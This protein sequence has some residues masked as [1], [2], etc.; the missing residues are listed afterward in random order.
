[1]PRRDDSALPAKGRIL[2]IDPGERRIGVAAADLDTRV[3]V[4][5]TTL[6]ADPDPVETVVACVRE[7]EAG[8]VVVGLALSM[9]G[10]LGA[11][12]QRAQAL[13]DALAERLDI[14]VY[15]WDE[16]LTSAEARRRLAPAKRSPRGR[17]ARRREV[18]A[19]AAAIVLQAFLDSE[20]RTARG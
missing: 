6:D 9:S 19:S 16:R 18:D 15:T 8:A 20:R 5:V 17:R 4:P 10:A 11:Q 3:A 12:G 1:M 13:A 2:A 14:P 7:Q